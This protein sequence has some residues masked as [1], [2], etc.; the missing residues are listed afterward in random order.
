MS[1]E[2][3]QILNDLKNAKL[4]INL[5]D[6]TEAAEDTLEKAGSKTHKDIRTSARQKNNEKTMIQDLKK[7]YFAKHAL[8]NVTQVTQ[9]LIVRKISLDTD[10]NF[11]NECSSIPHQENSA[12]PNRK[13]IPKRR[14]LTMT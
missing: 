5:D 1:R 3:Q 12:K 6:P 9:N 14:A 13:K 2:M 10:M 4:S 7:Q 11:S 8:H